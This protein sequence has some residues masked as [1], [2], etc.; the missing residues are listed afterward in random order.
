MFT[1]NDGDIIY[2]ALDLTLWR[3]KLSNDDKWTRIYSHQVPEN[4][5]RLARKY[6]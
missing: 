6:F 1:C 2:Q 4:I 5:R 3:M